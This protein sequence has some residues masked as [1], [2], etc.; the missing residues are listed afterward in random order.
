M[1][2]VIFSSCGALLRLV[3]MEFRRDVCTPA[4]VCRNFAIHAA[5][6]WRWH[7]KITKLSW[8]RM[9]S[10]V[11]H[12][13]AKLCLDKRVNCRDSKHDDLIFWQENMLV[14]LPSKEWQ[15]FLLMAFVLQLHN[16]TK[17]VIS[18]SVPVL[19]CWTV[20]SNTVQNNWF[21]GRKKNPT[22]CF[23]NTKKNHSKWKTSEQNKYNRKPLVYPHCL[24]RHRER[25]PMY[26]TRP[27]S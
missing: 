3:W 7:E 5:L 16:C 27:R 22:G 2:I 10:I 26:F 14:W 21:T 25:N 17:C 11:I 9:V 18:F 13:G 8:W 12:G 6:Q 19:S 1:P 15:I 20:L 23:W 4:S 24:S